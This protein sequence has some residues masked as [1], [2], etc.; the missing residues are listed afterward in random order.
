M[1][2]RV[3]RFVLPCV[4]LVLACDHPKTRL[5]SLKADLERAWTDTQPSYHR[6]LSKAYALARAAM[7]GQD[8]DT[9]YRSL[10]S[11]GVQFD[12][13][14]AP[15]GS[16]PDHVFEVDI[17]GLKH[18]VT[19]TWFT[20]TKTSHAVALAEVVLKCEPDCDAQQ[21]LAK[22]PYPRGSVVETV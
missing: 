9:V 14:D 2:Q 16:Q 8:I 15:K 4:L 1:R 5:D 18:K 22:M 19:L 10:D 21:F 7:D 3:A 11:Q 12:H 17:G 20:Q 13:F 6:F